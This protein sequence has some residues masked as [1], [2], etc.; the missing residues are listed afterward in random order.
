MTVSK[1]STLQLQEYKYKC[2][3]GQDGFVE[4]KDNKN[5]YPCKKCYLKTRETGK[6]N[7]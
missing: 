3:C 6:D 4:V 7:K 5:K 2:F 1:A